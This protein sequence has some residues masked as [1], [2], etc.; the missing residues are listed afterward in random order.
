MLKSCP[1]CK[2]EGHIMI[3]FVEDRFKGLVME[4]EECVTCNSL[5]YVDTR[6]MS[7]RGREYRIKQDRYHK[8]IS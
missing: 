7:T 4:T 6:K 2:G 1:K 8:T 5:G 3:G